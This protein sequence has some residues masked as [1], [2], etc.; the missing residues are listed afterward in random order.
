VTERRLQQRRS[1]ERRA[2]EF[3]PVLGRITPGELAES[4]TRR[5]ARIE[6]RCT[7]EVKAEMETVA[8]RFGLTVTDYILRL[9]ELAKSKLKE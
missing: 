6:I 3:S 2:D 4:L 7:A 8:G 9:H 1:S 5:D